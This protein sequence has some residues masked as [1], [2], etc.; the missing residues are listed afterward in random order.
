MKVLILILS[1]IFICGCFQ[2]KTET[3]KQR[4]H[5]FIRAI[6]SNQ[7]E[8]V[9]NSLKK[10]SYE[11]LKVDVGIIDPENGFIKKLIK[12][13]KASNP[14]YLSTEWVLRNKIAK[15][16][17][18]Y[19]NSKKDFLILERQNQQWYIN[20]FQKEKYKTSNISKFVAD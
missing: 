4:F 16:N 18:S 19:D 2:K 9:E 3:P 8:V 7:I 6:Q 15:I 10:G 1:S 5:I 17:Y 20:L 12:D 14:S 13:T 11:L